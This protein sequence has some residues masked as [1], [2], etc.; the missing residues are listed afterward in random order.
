MT[1]TTQTPLLT[2]EEERLWGLDKL[3]RSVVIVV[4]MPWLDRQ[5]GVP[6]LGFGMSRAEWYRSLSREVH[7]TDVPPEL[8]LKLS[9]R[10]WV[11]ERRHELGQST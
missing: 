8:P 7:G 11:R 10:S 1:Q 2:P 4:G 5:C 3:R 9:R 6:W